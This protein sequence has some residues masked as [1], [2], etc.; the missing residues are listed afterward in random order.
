MRSIWPSGPFST[1]GVTGRTFA[2]RA[3]VSASLTLLELSS[4]IRLSLVGK[5]TFHFLR[6]EIAPMGVIQIEST[7]S[8]P[9]WLPT[10]PT[11]DDARKKWVSKRFGMF[12]GVIQCAK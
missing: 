11:G 7:D 10:W 3:F 12:A 5:I 8:L 2:A 4:F 6:S 1:H 9:S